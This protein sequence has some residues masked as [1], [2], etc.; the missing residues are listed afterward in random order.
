M[1]PGTPQPVHSPGIHN[2]QLEQQKAGIE[3]CLDFYWETSSCLVKKAELQLFAPHLG[4]AV[5][6]TAVWEVP[7]KF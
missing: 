6:L 3:S 1:L 7:G 5:L 2:M 4:P